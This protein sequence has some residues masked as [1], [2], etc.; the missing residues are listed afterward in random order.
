MEIQAEKL[1]SYKYKVDKE[2]SVDGN[3]IK[4]KNI[5]LAPTETNIDYE[6]KAYNEEEEYYLNTLD[7]SIEHKEKIYGM[8][9]LGFSYNMAFGGAF[10]RESRS[11][12]TLYLENPDSITLILDLYDYDRREKIAY[13][14]DRDN[15]P[16]ELEYKGS[17]ITIESIR[18]TEEGTEIRIKEDESEDREYIRT[19]MY[20]E[21]QLKGDNTQQPSYTAYANFG[22]TR[23]N[24]KIKKQKIEILSELILPRANKM[25]L[26]LEGT[27]EEIEQI[28]NP[29][30]IYIEGQAY[31]VEPDKRIEI[32]LK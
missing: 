1:E 3:K 32:K 15:L 7:F 25:G 9:K 21:T 28:L 27:K 17:T 5:T 14:I 16:Q 26:D 4:I 8:S 23:K 22:V 13:D 12:E 10:T 31:T 11:L 24:E 29:Q 2:I 20:V 18:N 6:F 19:N 30:K